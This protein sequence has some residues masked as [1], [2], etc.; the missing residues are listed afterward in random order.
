MRDKIET[1]IKRMD[2]NP[3]I[4]LICDVFKFIDECDANKIVGRDFQGRRMQ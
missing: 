1:F 3:E 4:E 2:L